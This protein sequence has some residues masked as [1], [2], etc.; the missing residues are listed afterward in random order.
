VSDL[1]QQLEVIA[2][3]AP[4]PTGLRRD[5]EIRRAVDAGL[6]APAPARRVWPWAMLGVAAAAAAA[7]AIWVVTRPSAPSSGEPA[8][9]V[10]RG[11]IAAPA[12]GE[13][14]EVAAHDRVVLR[15]PDDSTIEASELTR[16]ERADRAATRWRLDLGHLESHVTKRAP[17][18]TFEVITPEATVAVV[19]TRFSVDRAVIDGVMTT[20]VAVEEG[21][22]RVTPVRSETVVLHAGEHWPRA[23]AAA[24]EPDRA[25]VAAD[26]VPDVAARDAGV[27]AT[28][29][30]ASADV[31]VARAPDRPRPA[32]P[33]VPARPARP[34]DA[35]AI[36]KII[37]AGNLADARRLI[38][39]GR[40]AASAAP[41][42][43]ELG[44]LAAEAEL[45]GRADRR[46]ID[47]YLAVVRDYPTTPQAEQAL[48]AAAQLAFDRPDAGYRPE[49][50]LRDYLDTYPHGQFAGDAQR[51]LDHLKK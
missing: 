4:A 8:I 16:F 5:H 44:I 10:E 3:A 20:R 18:E 47:L 32:A 22:V 50:M 33:A 45:A 1:E 14:V 49:A 23:S 25:A 39:D 21:V 46:A 37:H 42:L 48:F 34:F 19:G 11:A 13:L 30:D 38:D 6:A 12:T 28:T 24:V 26:A 7:I 40:K 51:L 36:R 15:T 2:D 9:V 27:D 35:T 41:D 43:A 31:E 17:G 29:I